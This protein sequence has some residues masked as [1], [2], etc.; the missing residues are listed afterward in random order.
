MSSNTF[1]RPIKYCKGVGYV[2][3]L[4]FVWNRW[5]GQ[6]WREF[7][8]KMWLLNTPLHDKGK[9]YDK[10]I[11]KNFT[12]TKVLLWIK[13]DYMYLHNLIL[14]KSSVLVRFTQSQMFLTCYG[15]SIC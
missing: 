14:A 7:E 6:V 10:K 11:D 5:I 12:K 13:C 4:K 3:R 8:E 1:D 9:I 15:Y 2:F